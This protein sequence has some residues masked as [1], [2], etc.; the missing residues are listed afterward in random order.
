MKTVENK[1]YKLKKTGQEEKM[2]IRL[3]LSYS[4]IW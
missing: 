4:V 3:V 2:F 1:R